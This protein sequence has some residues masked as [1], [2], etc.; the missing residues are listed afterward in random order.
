MNLINLPLNKIKEWDVFQLNSNITDE[1]IEKDNLTD[2]PLS[3]I[4][5]NEVYYLVDGYQRWQ[6]LKKLEPTQKILVLVFQEH[7]FQ[8]LW[9]NRIIYKFAN[10]QISYL[11]LGEALK[12]IAAHLNLSELEVWSKLDLKSIIPNSKFLQTLLEMNS[13]QEELKKLLPEKEWHPQIYKSF[14]KLKKNELKYIVNL[15]SGFAFTASQWRIIIDNL[16]DLK[17]L[18]NTPIKNLLDTIE[19]N[20]FLKKNPK[21]FFIIKE[22][23]FLLKNPVASSIYA[24]RAEYLKS[25]NLPDNY[26]LEYSDNFEN[27]Y[28]E[29]KIKSKNLVELKKSLNFFYDSVESNKNKLEKLY[30]LT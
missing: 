23:L 21:A 8:K 25:L 22:K 14:G 10:K 20:S 16:C 13:K 4:K 9:K 1:L 30:S 28:L 3:V 24:K 6:K 15:L 7:F 12:K 26:K 29:L 11:A 27:K 5:M 18:K 19:I 17:L 2:Y